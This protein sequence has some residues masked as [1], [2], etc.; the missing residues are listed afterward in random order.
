[1]KVLIVGSHE[2]FAIENFYM[3][4]LKVLGVDIHRFSAQSIFYGYYDASIV[5]KVLYKLGLS[6]IYQKING[7]FKQVVAELEPEIIWV[8][9]GMEILPESLIWAK[10]RGIKLAN[11]N[12]DNPFVFSGKGSGNSNVTKSIDLYD[13]HFTYNLEIQAEL[14]QKHKAKTSFLPF[15]YDVSPD[16]YEECAKE[17][18]VVKACFLGNPDKRRAD[19][20]LQLADNGVK[21]DVYGHNWERF[22]SH[23]NI[24]V[25]PPV[26]E[27]EL[28]KTLR[29]YRVQLNLMRIHNENS[30]NMRSFEI[31]GI[32]GIQVAPF[33]IEHQTFF[34]DGK[35]V[36]LYKNLD[37]C[38]AKINYILA[39]SPKKAS[40]FRHFARQA[41]LLN[42]HS[43]KD[44]SVQVVKA[45]TSLK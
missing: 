27:A 23:P 14:E 7:Q 26:Y 15:A 5:N 28:W 9:K 42:K 37:E 4:Y 10:Q 44:R 40:D 8:F 33:T 45:L 39:L 30:H 32:G 22:I 18:E 20:I 36:F 1:M 24:V 3:K 38:V 43:Y 19:F 17:A 31:P 25:C 16:W 41:S 13:L 34:E 2:K 29:K 11:Y 35:E 21:M 6:S 12:P